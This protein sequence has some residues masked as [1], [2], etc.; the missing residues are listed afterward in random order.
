MDKT[1][2]K[3]VD[4]LNKQLRELGE[5]ARKIIEDF[6]EKHG[7]YKFPNADYDPIYVGEGYAIEIGK[8]DWGNIVVY[9]SDI[10]IMSLHHMDDEDILDLAEYLNEVEE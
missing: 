9:D 7:N 8:D 3:D 1:F 4:N 2:S 10:C 5:R 6:V